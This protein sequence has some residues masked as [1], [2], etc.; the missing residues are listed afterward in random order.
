[1]TAGAHRPVDLLGAVLVLSVTS[2]SVLQGIVVPA[3]PTMAVHLHSTTSGVTWVFTAYL[4]SASVATP[5][6]GRVG[7]LYGMRRTYLGILAALAAGC[8]LAALAPGLP[9]MIAA[10]VLQGAGG[11]VLPLAF[12]VIRA[13]YPPARV[14]ARITVVAAV[15]F[16][17]AGLGTAVAGPV[18][19]HLGYV[20]LFL[21]PMTMTVGSAVAAA[22]VLPV[23]R[24]TGGAGLNIGAVLLMSTWLVALLLV[25][26]EGN[27]WGWS[28]PYVLGLV[29]VGMVAA[30]GWATA[31]LRSRVPLVDLRMLRRR[32]IVVANLAALLLGAAMFGN[33]LVIQV[34]LQSPGTSYGFGL[35]VTVSSLVALPQQALVFLVGLG[36]GAVVRRIGYRVTLAAGGLINGLGI[37]LTVVARDNLVT[38]CLCTALCGI[39]LGLAFTALALLVVAV[40]P[41]EQTG[42]ASGTNANVR[43]IGGAVGTSA[44]ATIL[45]ATAIAGTPAES[46]VMLSLAFFAVAAALSGL[47]GLLLPR[48]VA[49]HAAA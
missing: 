37:T 35:T 40:V 47:A 31:E 33:N 5:V 10:R 17:G 22:F 28:S 45:S 32:A 20:W 19:D 11:G 6:L 7:D 34:L 42:V 30:L 14:S 24:R 43:S 44:T 1:M 16:G 29:P 27:A 2:F 4:L 23:T 21:V 3:L 36:C 25:I 8:L 18:L 38:V 9:A 13:A 39:G 46:G 48:V 41:P 49:H 26:S 15:A 12:G